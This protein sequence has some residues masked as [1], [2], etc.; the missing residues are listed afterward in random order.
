MVGA[1]CAQEPLDWENPQVVGRNKEPGHCTL[2]PYV[3]VATALVGSREASAWH[4]SLNGNWKFYWVRTPEERPIDF[5]RPDYDV[6][7]WAEIPV[8]S[9]WQMHGYDIPIYTNAAYPFKNDPP[10]INHSFNPVGSYRREFEVPPEWAGQEVYIHFDGVQ[11]AFYLWVNGQMVGYSEDSRTP[12]EFNITRYLKPG[13]NLLA[14]EDYRWCDGSYLEDQD[15]WRLSGIYRDVYLMA[16][17]K[18]HVRDYWFRCDLD[19]QY[20]DATLKLTAKIRN[21]G[22]TVGPHT[23]EVRMLEH[24]K[25]SPDVAPIL[26]GT[27]GPLDSGAEATL[28]LQTQVTNPRKW[29][30]E[31]PNLYV[32]L[33]TLKDVGGKVVEV[34]RCNFGFREVELKDRRFWIN[35]VPTYIKGVNRHEHDPDTGNYVSEARMVQD[36]LLMKRLNIN[37]VRTCHYPDDPKW[38]DLCD[39][40]GIMLIDEANVES[41]GALRTVP[42][43]DPVW[44][45]A[46]LDRV[47]R[48][49]ERDKNHPSVVIWSL[50]NEAGSGDNFKKM[51]DYVHQ[52]DPTR[53]VHYQHMNSVADIDS[54]MYPSVDSLIARG[55]SSSPKPFIMCEY[56]H[57]MGNAIGNLQEYWDAIETYPPLIGGCIWDW[58]D[59][60]LRKWTV[61]GTSTPDRASG[62]R[63]VLHGKLSVGLRGLAL[64]SGW[65][66]L[67][68]SPALNITGTELTLEAWVKPAPREGFCP[69]VG[70][71]DTQYMLRSRD[72]QLEFFIFDGSWQMVSAPLPADWIGTWH[73]VAG[74]YD[75]HALRL[76]CDRKQ[77]GQK[78]CTSAIVA[79]EYPVNVGRNSQHTDRRFAG[80]IDL[81]RIYNR[82]LAPEELGKADATPPPSAV[83]WLDFDQ[84][85]PDPDFRP[86]WFWAYGGDYGDQPNSG[87]FCLNGVV[88]PDRELPPKAWEVK[89][90]YQYVGFTPEDLAAGKIRIKNKYFDTNLDEFYETW[91]MLEDGTEIQRGELPPLRAAPGTET[92]LTVPFTMPTPKPGAE[93]WLRVNFHLSHDTNWA[94]RGQIVAWEQFQLPVQAP[95]PIVDLAKVPPLKLTETGGEVRLTGPAF[96]IV[97]D[98]VQGTISSLT[99]G[100]QA[101]IAPSRDSA[102][103][104]RLN[105]F[106]AP[107]NNDKQAGEWYRAG[108][109]NLKCSTEAVQVE[110]LAP[111]VAQVTVRSFSRG[112]A[113]AGFAHTCRYTVL[114]DGTVHVDNAIEPRGNLP[115]LPKLGV[116]MSLDQS[117]ENLEWYG[118]GPHEN[119]VDRKRSAEVGRYRS[120]V[121]EQYVRYPW[122]QETGNKEEVRWAALT[123]ADGSG[124]LVVA[125]RTFSMTALHF[126]AGDLVRAKHFNELTP[127][128]EVI[129]CVD[130]AQC[131]LGNGSCGPGVLPKYNLRPVPARY[132]F[133]LRP[134][135][136]ALG[137]PALLAHPELPL[138]QAPTV[139]R[140]EAGVLNITCATAGATIHYTT[141]GTA[142]TEASRIFTA[143]LPFLEGGTVRAV[144]M[145][146]GRLP[147]E[148]VSVR[149][150]HHL[151]DLARGKP[152]Q[153]SSV[154]DAERAASCGNDGDPQTR[155]CAAGGSVP[156]WWQ[157]DLGQTREV[158]A[159]E[160]HWEFDDRQYGYKV[161]G[162]VDAKDW[163]LL[164]DRSNNPERGQVQRVNF[165]PA[166]VRYVRLTLLSLQAEPMT[167]ASLWEVKVMGR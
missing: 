79:C 128:P 6:S 3:D 143:P 129:L 102:N 107:T 95:R 159:V 68:D 109:N 89:K 113:D 126:T 132:G 72:G 157:V 66:E 11:S 7:G 75:G 98:K 108:L 26:T 5:Y 13:R 104:P 74:V 61:R 140:D 110:R 111:G 21:L 73:H 164:A 36:I 105:A 123:N 97:F 124:V 138:T 150:S 9:N 70:K 155:W 71:G 19:D 54:T 130:Y 69:I 99:Y 86:T 4:R 106:R 88:F 55:K 167:W 62:T 121:T 82:A 115:N 23:L 85:G 10:R 63:A 50:G 156:Q 15:M 34:Q 135:T 141:D 51:A 17:P 145:A 60:G 65:A 154:Q 49:V 57:A 16:T 90:V 149:L 56:A 59:Q 30:C 22:A 161:E 32:L 153:A 42:D 151:T 116:V 101:I 31:H 48:M 64:D 80:L 137:D 53:P 1:A 24:A 112:N 77:V 125:D 25:A 76:Y 52:T 39:E 28:E 134:L 78:P 12:A 94:D 43:S 83:A 118:R 40:Y 133:S 147:S 146:P 93:Y 87:N 8:P 44:T 148:T 35:G 162:S 91:S 163:R 38:Y 122:P 103:G 160:I 20:R 41:H 33:L 58:V 45:E 27:T 152:A 92:L 139:T 29:T 18:V 14:V 136:P 119:Y 142:P 96:E 84:A 47:S 67:P 100:A 165:D 117:L 131:G 158:E 127:R 37:A 120:T 46:C 81:V 2:M 114:G 166:S 144:A